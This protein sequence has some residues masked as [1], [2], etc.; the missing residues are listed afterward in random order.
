MEEQ[1]YQGEGVFDLLGEA[2]EALHERSHTATLFNSLPYTR[3]WWQHFGT[4]GRL[5]IWTVW[6][7]EELIAIA[8]LYEAETEQGTTVLRFLGGVDISD[9]LD[10]IVAPGRETEAAA[11]LLA[12]WADAPCSCPIDLHCLRHASPTREAFLRLA[13]GAGFA[14]SEVREEVCPVITLPDTWEKYLEQLE[15]KQRRELRRKL[16]RAGHE[17]LVSW[18]QVR[19]EQVEEEMECFFRLHALS[20]AEKATFMTTPMRAFFCDLALTF[21]KLGWLDLIFLLVD[22]VPVATYLNFIFRDEV[23]V[24][25]S[26]FDGD[27]GGTLSPGWLLLCYHIEDAI[28]RGRTRYDFLRG[29]ETYKFRFGAIAEPIFQ[30]QLTKP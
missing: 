4:P 26:G 16:R 28:A 3:L 23:W 18:Y 30:L 17:A 24:Y 20:D 8:P 1:S 21:S 27:K 9:Y 22:G 25:N 29:E 14:I 5:Q 7:K 11:A 6:D 19:P 2:W 10:I 12:G 13:P 15:G